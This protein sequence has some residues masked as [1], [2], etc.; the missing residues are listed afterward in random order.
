MPYL[1]SKYAKSDSLYPKDLVIRAKIDQRFHF[2]TAIIFSGA[3]GSFVVTWNKDVWSICKLNLPVFFQKTI[4]YGGKSEIQ[5]ESVE[6][7]HKAYDFTEKLLKDEFL[8]G[9]NLTLAD[10]SCCIDLLTL[11]RLVAIDKNKYP[12]LAAWMERVSSI[13]NFHEINDDGVQQLQTRFESCLA[14]NKLNTS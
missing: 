11:D 14:A 13:P 3:I 12:K 9:N 7:T 2:D 4:L 5:E 1:V 10:I 6:L 8:V